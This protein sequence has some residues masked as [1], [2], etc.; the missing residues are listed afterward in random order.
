M[1]KITR[2]IGGALLFSGIANANLLDGVSI[3]TD[4]SWFL[5]SGF[6][7]GIEVQTNWDQT[8]EVNGSFGKGNF[9]VEDGIVGSGIETNLYMSHKRGSV[10]YNWYEDGVDDDSF[11]LSGLTGIR[12][13]RVGGDNREGDASTVSSPY[14]GAAIGRRFKFESGINLRTGIGAVYGKDTNITYKDK[15]GLILVRKVSGMP[16]M[17]NGIE[18]DISLSYEF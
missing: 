6:S 4:P 12:I 5:Y 17:Q 8:L 1:N 7:G 3:T 2:L 15:D 14:L 11:Y 16:L 10:R 13:L 18:S 9:D